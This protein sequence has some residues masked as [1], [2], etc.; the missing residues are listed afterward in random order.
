MPLAILIMLHTTGCQKMTKTCDM[1]IWLKTVILPVQTFFCCIS[2]LVL[3][4]IIPVVSQFSQSWTWH[5]LK[6]KILFCYWR[7]LSQKL[8]VSIYFALI[9]KFQNQ[10]SEERMK[11]IGWNYTFSKWIVM[12]CHTISKKIEKSENP[13]WRVEPCRLILEQAFGS[14]WGT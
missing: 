10:T 1:H 4:C 13:S 6:G 5:L 8:V 11:F 7:W 14:W 3:G 9:L 2:K 12:L